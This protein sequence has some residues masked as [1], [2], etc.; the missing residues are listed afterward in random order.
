M[1]ATSS[2]ALLDAWERALHVPCGERGVA[3]LSA[4]CGGPD[5][6]PAL[7]TGGELNVRLLELRASLFGAGP[8]AVVVCARCGERTEMELELDGSAARRSGKAGPLFVSETGWDVSLRLPDGRDLHALAQQRASGRDLRRGLLARCV[9][10]ASRD[11]AA[12]PIGDAPD[13]VVDA[14]SRRMAEADPW[15]IIEIDVVCAACGHE[16]REALNVESFVWSEIQAWAARVLDEVHQLAAAYG[17]GEAEI[18]ALT[19]QRRHA[20][21]ELAGE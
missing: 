4:A 6:D 20:Y 21:L 13:S 9:L 15:A 12:A 17:W 1:R 14:I 5:E 3:L 11:G 2:A 19:P 16:W 18:L 7:L 10:E 8:V